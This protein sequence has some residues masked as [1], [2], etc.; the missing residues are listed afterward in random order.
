MNSVQ[1]KA[2]L[3]HLADQIVR[4]QLL[5]PAQFV[6]DMIEPLGFFASQI[7]LFAQPFTPL[8][9]WHDYLSA[10]VDEEGWKE[11]HTIVKRRDS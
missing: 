6:L 2:I 11:L 5:V 3:G 7:V 4:R 8:G 1:R 10:L 9:R